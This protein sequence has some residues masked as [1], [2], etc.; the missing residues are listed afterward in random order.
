MA[1]LPYL[2]CVV[3]LGEIK[4]RKDGPGGG[5][6]FGFIPGKNVNFVLGD[7]IQELGFFSG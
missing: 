2:S 4:A 3:T 1:R 6:K 5:G 7:G